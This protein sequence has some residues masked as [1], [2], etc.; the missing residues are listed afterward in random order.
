[1]TQRILLVGVALMGLLCA[2]CATSAATPIKS[3]QEA[4]AVEV[5]PPRVV[6]GEELAPRGFAS[7]AEIRSS[8]RAASRQHSSCVVLSYSPA[9]RWSQR[10][11]WS[12]RRGS[13]WGG[14]SSR[15]RRANM[16]ND[17]LDAWA[18]SRFQNHKRYTPDFSRTNVQHLD[19]DESHI[20]KT[21]GY[22]IYTISGSSLFI[23]DVR[24]GKK[25]EVL[26][27]VVLPGQATGMFIKDD[28]VAVMGKFVDRHK[29][30][31]DSQHDRLTYVA[32]FDV[33]SRDKP[34]LLVR[35]VFEGRPIDAR[36]FN[37]VAYFVLGSRAFT[38]SKPAPAMAKGNHSRNIPALQT[39]AY[40]QPRRAPSFASVHALRMASPSK[41]SSKAVLMGNPTVVYMSKRSLY[42]ADTISASAADM[43][44]ALLPELVA[45]H[46]TQADHTLVADIENVGANVFSPLEKHQKITDVYCDRLDSLES[47]QRD[48]LRRRAKVGVSEQLTKMGAFHATAIHRIDIDGMDLSLGPSGQ[49]PGTPLNQFSFDEH[50]GHLRVATT[51]T[52]DNA[53]YAMNASLDVVGKLEG[54]GKGER[55]YA[56]RYMGERVYLVTFRRVDPFYVVDAAVPTKLRELGKLKIPGVSRYLHPYG[57]KKV[58]G[59]GS[60]VGARRGLKIQL[61]DVSDVSS[62]RVSA[63]FVSDDLSPQI[64]RYY[65]HRALLIDRPKRLLTV[66][67]RSRKARGVGVLVLDAGA[68]GFKRRGVIFH[69]GAQ[70]TRIRTQNIQGTVYVDNVLFTRSNAMVKA[71]SLDDL[72]TVTTVFL[73]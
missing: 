64:S 16:I 24:R 72:S 1:M 19:I 36:M 34:K 68:N 25:N 18:S 7:Q 54:L 65:G 61:F 67:V 26:G 37:G 33:G 29:L 70:W 14:N 56:V 40:R 13:S 43:A 22:F 38:R 41:V 31:A 58:L 52:R 45:S 71:S 21:D 60:K 15:F 32:V 42:L 12:A 63:S 49:V 50:K 6:L 4:Q 66:P 57:A 10:R 47:S 27:S 73:K 44:M 28:R 46:L 39:V 3:A 35:H 2:G 69:D 62:P 17:T 55:I 48:E 30:I 9:S 11:D 53:V 5:A 51:R 59:I 20:I 23:V 8:I